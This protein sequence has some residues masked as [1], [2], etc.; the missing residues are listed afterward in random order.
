MECYCP[1]CMHCRNRFEQRG[2]DFYHREGNYKVLEHD[3]AEDLEGWNKLNI[4][5]A[6]GAAYHFTTCQLAA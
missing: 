4:E 1:V 3:I 6:K 2:H 5:Q